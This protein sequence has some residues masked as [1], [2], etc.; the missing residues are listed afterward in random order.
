VGAAAQVVGNQVGG[1]DTD[2]GLVTTYPARP[3]NCRRPGDGPTR[4]KPLWIGYGG[5][6]GD[7]RAPDPL[8]QRA[9]IERRV[10]PGRFEVVA[11][12]HPSV[13]RVTIRSPR[14]I[15]TLVP[16][17]RGHVVFALYDGFFPAGKLVVTAHLRGGGTYSER[18]H[19]L[20]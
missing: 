6:S 11:E 17:E 14:D 16:S 8:L 12:C 13:E 4:R 18:F 7:T 1:V 9:R 5:G 2:Y 15:R 3:V 19:L 10:L 20:L